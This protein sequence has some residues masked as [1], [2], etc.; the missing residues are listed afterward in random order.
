[1]KKTFA[2]LCAVAALA[3]CVTTG[4]GIAAD[5][6]SGTK[7][8]CQFDPTTATVSQILQQHPAL[9]AKTIAGL[10]CA[11]VAPLA[12]GPG[13]SLTPGYVGTVKVHG[14]FTK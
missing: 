7:A 13:S 8:L 1:M 10:V 6:I 2:T 4:L 9:D 14:R 12:S 3:G 11:A 5:V